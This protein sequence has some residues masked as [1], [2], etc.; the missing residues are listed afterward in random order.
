MYNT[1]AIQVT[2]RLRIQNQ[3]ITEIGLALTGS[4]FVAAMA[5]LAVYL[6]FTPVPIT[7]QTFAVL[8]IGMVYGSRLG[9]LTMLAYLAEGATGLPFFAGGLGGPVVLAGPTG[10]YLLGFVAAAWLVGLLAERGADRR[11]LTAMLAY[12]A[13]NLA[14][15]A[16]G[17]CWLAS[18]FGFNR[19]L[20]I[21]LLPFLAGDALKA[22]LA[23]IALPSAWAL[24]RRLQ[25]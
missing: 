20:H 22:L 5:Q 7:G 3:A 24:V 16:F 9:A 19:A 2:Q 14:I 21:G 17:L 10:G 25:G 4:L 6:P 18:M 1:L 23:G 13:G 8:L 15:Y 12:I 11:P